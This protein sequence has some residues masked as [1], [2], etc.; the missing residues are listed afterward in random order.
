MEEILH[1]LICN[2]SHYLQGFSIIPGGCWGF[3]PAIAMLGNPRGYHSFHFLHPSEN[4]WQDSETSK[5]V[6]DDGGRG[7]C[8][9]LLPHPNAHE[10]LLLGSSQDL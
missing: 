5:D 8:R 3:L 7:C 9:W 2:L 6:G 4:H 10:I 1:Q